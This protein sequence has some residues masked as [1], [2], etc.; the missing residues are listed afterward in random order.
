[1]EWSLSIHVLA[2]PSS[3]FISEGGVTHNASLIPHLHLS[4]PVADN[5]VLVKWGHTIGYQHSFVIAFLCQKKGWNLCMQLSPWTTNSVI[6]NKG[7]NLWKRR[8]ISK[9]NFWILLRT[10]SHT[11][12]NKLWAFWT[13]Q[14]FLADVARL[15]P[16]L[17]SASA[18][19][20]TGEESE[21]VHGSFLLFKV[22][23]SCMYA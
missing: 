5:H 21:H 15:T 6:D 16:P 17:P 23:V 4:G 14:M 10:S 8:E 20:C 12:L 19:P 3:T 2:F 22:F 1:M 13:E 11:W 7:Y 18:L 9:Q